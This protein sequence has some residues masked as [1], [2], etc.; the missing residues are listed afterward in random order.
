MH[1]P[2]TPLHFKQRAV[3][4]YG[5]KVGVV[6]GR[7]RFTYAE[8]GRRTN[9]LANGLLSRGL[10]RGDRV[11]VLAFNGHPLLE[12]YYGVVEAGGILLPLNVRLLPGELARIVDHAKPKVLIVDA[13]L[14]DVLG[15]IEQEAERRFD[16]IWIGE[17]P[18]GRDEQS[19]EE[20]LGSAASESPPPLCVDEDDVAELFYTSGTTG[21]PRG[22][23]LSHRSLTLHALSMLI[24]FRASDRDVQLHTIP[25][26]HV[27]GW[28]TPQGVTAVGGTHVMLRKFDAAEALR[29]VEAERVTRIFAVPTMLQMLLEELPRQDRDLTSLELIDVGGA[30]LSAEVVK[31]AEA[32][33]GCSVIGGYGLT[34]TCPIVSLATSKQTLAGQDE[35]SRLRRQATAGLPLVG[36][37]LAIVDQE[38]RALPWDGKAVGEVVVRSNVVTTGYWA[39]RPASEEAFRNGWFHTGDLG[40]I[41][42]EGYLLIVDRIKDII[43]SGGENVSSLEVERVVSEHE[44]VLECVVVGVPDERWGEVAK[45]IVALREGRQLS[46]AELIDHCRERLSAF[47]VPK[48]VAFEAELPKGGTGKIL[49]AELRERYWRGQ[50][51]RVH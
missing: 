43:V 9:Q 18:T 29:L 8:L 20:L 12:A 1:V 32:A 4:L 2:L 24:A 38:D 27:N 40:T 13:E 50:P 22:V 25:L 41:D 23:M 42:P 10:A 7:C 48:T 21:Q 46:E 31:R 44:A 11:A 39:E 51:K 16:V 37:E 14:S 47:K 26:F 28:G 15:R 6:D 5:S 49:K 19:Y 36:V 17:R 33:L 3:Q 35:A 30:P 45:A 34:E